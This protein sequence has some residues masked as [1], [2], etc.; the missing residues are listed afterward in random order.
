MVWCES[1]MSV[2]HMIS[3]PKITFKTIYPSSIAIRHK[4]TQNCVH[5]VSMQR[6]LLSSSETTEA[7][8]NNKIKIYPIEIYLNV[9]QS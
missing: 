2:I 7:K 5:N 1:E 8:K 9:S 4:Q 6:L 3:K